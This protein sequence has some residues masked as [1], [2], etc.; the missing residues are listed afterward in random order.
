MT[1]EYGMT[2]EQR[3]L[4]LAACQVSD[5]FNLASQLTDD[6]AGHVPATASLRRD[7]EAHQHTRHVNEFGADV[8][9]YASEPVTGNEHEV[10]FAATID[11]ENYWVTIER[12]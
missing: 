7:E 3:K 10:S 2:G 6:G 4:H 12:M 11:G 9:C 5:M 8:C 1:D